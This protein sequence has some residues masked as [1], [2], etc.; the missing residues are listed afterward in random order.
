MNT[1]GYYEKIQFTKCNKCRKFKNLRTS[2]GFDKTLVLSIICNKYDSIDK[3]IFKE[4]KSIEILNISAS[5][6]NTNE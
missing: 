4:K 1:K 2:Y 6:N 5:I 3:K